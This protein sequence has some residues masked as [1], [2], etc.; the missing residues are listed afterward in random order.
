MYESVE[1]A[2]RAVDV[3]GTDEPLDFAAIHI[4]SSFWKG[5]SGCSLMRLMAARDVVLLPP[6]NASILD[7]IG[8]MLMV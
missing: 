3:F 1:A 6:V 5:A 8:G 2:P 7:G 4:P